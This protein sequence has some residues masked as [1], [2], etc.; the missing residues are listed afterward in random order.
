MLPDIAGEELCRLLR[1]KSRV[2]VIML[3]AKSGEE[4]KLTG[5]G[6]GADDYITKPFSLKELTARIEAV[7]RRAEDEPPA[8]SLSF[9]GGDLVIDFAANRVQK[10]GRS[11]NL[12]LSEFN[13]LAALIKYAGRVLTRN[14]LIE[15]AL[16]EE[17][18]GFDRA[19]DSHVKNLRGK[20]EDDPKSPVYVLTVRGLGYRF[21]G[22]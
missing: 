3:T 19:V 12:T 14:Q 17:F 2:P 15:L 1:R 4:D 10:N 9:G 11:A 16:G 22:E 20:I 13:I 18:S 7:L 21:G 6:L 5:L 8:D